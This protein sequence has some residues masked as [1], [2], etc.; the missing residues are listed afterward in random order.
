MK[1]YDATALFPSVPIGELIRVILNH[2]KNDPNLHLRTKLSLEKICDLASLCLSSSNF[3][4]NGRHHY[5]LCSL[6]YDVVRTITSWL[7]K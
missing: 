2:L 4:F 3:I 1:S 6:V 5:V 7:M